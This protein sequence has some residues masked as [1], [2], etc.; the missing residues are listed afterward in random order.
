VI[1]PAASASRE[2]PRT[3]LRAIN[4]RRIAL[5]HCAHQHK[6]AGHHHWRDHLG[7]HIQQTNSEKEN[8]GGSGIAKYRE[9]GEYISSIMAASKNSGAK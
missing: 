5:A 3:A 2:T 7:S 4:K 8:I 9:E 6:R 1:S